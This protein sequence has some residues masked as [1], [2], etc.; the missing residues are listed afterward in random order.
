MEETPS[1][2]HIYLK[3][4]R[5]KFARAKTAKVD[6]FLFGSLNEKQ[7]LNN[8]KYN[9]IRNLLKTESNSGH[10]AQPLKNYLNPVT[11]YNLQPRIIK[12]RSL[13]R[14]NSFKEYL[15]SFSRNSKLKSKL[16]YPLL[17]K[18]ANQVEE[19]SNQI[20]NNVRAISSNANFRVRSILKNVQSSREE[21]EKK[22][23]NFDKLNKGKKTVNENV[24]Y[25][26]KSVAKYDLE[27][28]QILQYKNNHF[29]LNPRYLS[30][31]SS[32]LRMIKM[33]KTNKPFMRFST[34]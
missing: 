2:Q 25:S 28:A 32:V 16:Y 3:S 9:K 29:T 5:S 22:I 7:K 10:L 19:F 12:V 26:I 1:F 17:I 33:A 13:N 27:S 24:K 11:I 31:L 6:T 4:D 21:F 20:N 34:K 23:I 18:Q 8:L 15:N 30:T 14:L